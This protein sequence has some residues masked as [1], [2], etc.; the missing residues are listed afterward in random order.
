FPDPNGAS[1]AL[2]DPS[3]DNNAGGNWCTSSTPFGDGD[4]GTPGAANDCGAV[5]LVINEIDY[6]QPGGDTA[7]FVEIKNAGASGLD[8]AGMELVLVNGTGGGASIYDTIALPAV[9]LGAGDYFVVCSSAATVANCDLEAISSIQNGAPDAVALRFGG[10]VIVD[11]VSYEGDT[12][13]PY[14]EGSGAGLEDSGAAGQ[15]FRGISRYPDGVDTDQNNADLVNACITPGG[16]N[17]SFAGPCSPVGPVLEIYEI[18]GAGTASPVAGVT[19]RTNDNAVTALGTNGFFMQTPTSRTD[20]DVDTSDGIFVFTGGAPTV[21]VGDRVDVTGQVVEFFGL[22]EFSGGVSVSTVGSGPVPA[23]VALDAFVPSPTPATPSCAIEYECYEGMLVEVADGYVAGGNQ[24]FGSD[25]F[26]EIHITAAGA[27]PFREPGIEFPGLPGFPVWD[28]NPEVFELDPDKLGLPNQRIPAGSTF[29]ARGVIGFEFNHFE[30]WPTELSVAPAPLPVPVRP[31]APDELTIGSLNLFRLFDDVDDPPSVNVVGATRN[32]AVVS[33]A[34][35][36]RRRAKL[37][38]QIVGVLR[39]P[40][41]LAVQ[42]AEKIEVLQDLAADVNAIDPAVNYTAYLIEG[43]DVGTIDVGFLV[44]DRVQ[45]VVVTQLGANELF[46]FDD[47]DS[48]LHDRPPLLLEGLCDGT[49]PIKVMVLH[50]RSLGGIDTERVQ[51]KRYEQAES[52]ATKIQDIQSADPDVNLVV[53]G[54][55]NAFEFTDGYVDV[56]GIIKGD[57]VP[58]DSV[59]CGLPGVACADLVDPDLTDQ[60]LAIDPGQRYSFI[61]RD[62]F[63]PVRSRGDSQV[64]DHAMT[65]AALGALVTGY[66]YGRANADAPEELLERD[67]TEPDAGPDDLFLRA[68]DH[69]GLVL[70]LFKDEDGDGVTDALDVCPGTEIPESVPTSGLGV[71]R[72][73]LTDGDTAFDTTPPPGGGNGPGLSFTTQDTAGCSCEQIID[74]QGLGSGHEKYGCSNSAM[75]EWVALVNPLIGVSAG[76]SRGG[77]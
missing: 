52:V 3:L 11:T 28:G 47:P 54:D 38:A 37:A 5:P 34:E 58:A 23:P 63:N 39:S 42:E 66:E 60:V 69:D 71:N 51:R 61:F 76:S 57:F 6:D 55:F 9:T 45:G 15:D 10:A 36:L 62:T 50:Q 22:T 13:A 8:L 70:Y 48:A 24:E 1:M 68:S 32:D 43:N 33:G 7:E 72:W 19:V 2:I 41:I 27:R 74:A 73:A 67:G 30:L 12:G 20:G 44:R 35:Y 40:D 29:T 16:A 65:S 53:V 18:Q 75:E 17:T 64:L 31:A 59:V 77:R 4:R 25:P 56:A 26:A 49:F 46:T 21:G 14:T